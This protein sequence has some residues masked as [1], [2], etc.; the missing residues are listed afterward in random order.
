MNEDKE[1][2]IFYLVL[3]PKDSVGSPGIT[4]DQMSI[5]SWLAAGRRVFILGTSK[6]FDEI[7]KSEIIVE[8][9]RSE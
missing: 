8:V 2:I 1:D 7:T 4:I 6:D 9:T 3:P 5:P